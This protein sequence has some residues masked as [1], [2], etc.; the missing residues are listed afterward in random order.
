MNSF[1]ITKAQFNIMAKK[2]K[3]LWKIKITFA[4]KKLILESI[5]KYLHI[6][7]D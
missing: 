2:K 5:M 1:S 7:N 4:L 3:G 6:W